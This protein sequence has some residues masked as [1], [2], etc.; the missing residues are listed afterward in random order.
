MDQ[1][2]IKNQLM[3]LRD[4]LMYINPQLLNYLG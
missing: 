3:H 4:L 1:Q 2:H